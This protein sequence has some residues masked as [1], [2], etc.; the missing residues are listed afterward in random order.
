MQKL[1]NIDLNDVYNI[2]VFGRTRAGK[3][4]FINWLINTFYDSIPVKNIIVFSP[5]FRTDNSYQTLR[6]KMLNDVQGDHT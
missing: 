2:A 1:I 6:Y 3:S 4:H 5:S